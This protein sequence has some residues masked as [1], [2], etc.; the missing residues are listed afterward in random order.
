MILISKI[1]GDA[2]GRL[3]LRN[4][5]VS[6]D[7]ENRARIAR[8]ATLDGSS[9]FSHFGVTDTDRDFT[10]SCRLSPS[11]FTTLKTIFESAE[12]IRISF[13]EGAFLGLIARLKSLRNGESA[14]TFYFKEKLTS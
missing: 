12:T 8:S 9:H 4:Y 5:Q 3:A 2:N 13:W 6:G 10:V 7:Y 11:E 14:I 1:T